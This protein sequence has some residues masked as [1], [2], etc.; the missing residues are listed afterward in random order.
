MIFDLKITLEVVFILKFFF[1]FSILIDGHLTIDSLIGTFDHSLFSSLM[2][3][4]IQELSK[5]ELLDLLIKS[6]ELFDSQLG[7]NYVLILFST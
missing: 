5:V 1:R 6:L 2:I 7:L 4:R 3:G